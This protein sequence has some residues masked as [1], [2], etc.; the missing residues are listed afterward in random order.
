MVKAA[1]YRM[2]RVTSFL[3]PF[4]DPTGTGFQAV[5]GMY[6]LATG[7]VLGRRARATAR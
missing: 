1:P 6:A 3:D 7:G 4:A 5:R 2:A